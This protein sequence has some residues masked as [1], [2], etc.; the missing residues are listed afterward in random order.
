MKFVQYSQHLK[1]IFHSR[2]IDVI[3]EQLD[4]HSARIDLYTLTFDIRLAFE[5][6][7]IVEHS[8]KENCYTSGHNFYRHNI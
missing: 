8:G 3:L 5:C 1:I 4:E 2:Y 7:I 6:I